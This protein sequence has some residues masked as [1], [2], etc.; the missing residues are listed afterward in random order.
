MSEQAAPE[1]ETLIFY[2]TLGCHLCDQAK[3]I[4]SE[5]LNPEFFQVKEQDIADDDALIER[6]GT[7]IPVLQ[8][9][10]DGTELGWPFDHKD[11]VVF[12]SETS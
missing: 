8:R 4:M 10:Q 11:L 9:C 12:L 3:A 5:T 7:R 2:T 1:A 6:Y